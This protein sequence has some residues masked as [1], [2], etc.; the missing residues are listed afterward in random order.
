MWIV[1]FIDTF[2]VLFAAVLN[3]HAATDY[4]R[5]NIPNLVQAVQ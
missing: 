1:G 4:N 2:L 5:Q 3:A